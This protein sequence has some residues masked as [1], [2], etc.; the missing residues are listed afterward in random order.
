MIENYLDAV[1]HDRASDMPACAAFLLGMIAQFVSYQ[2]PAAAHQYATEGLTLARETGMPSAIAINLVGLA[3]AV[4]VD[5]PDQARALLAEA[6]RLAATLDYENLNELAGAVFIAA[7]LQEW[8]TVLRASGRVLHLFNRS[9]A[10]M[11]KVIMVGTLNFVT[12]GLAEHQPETAAVLQGAIGTMMRQLAPD[13]AA[14]ARGSTSGNDIAVFAGGVRRDTT[15]RLTAALGDA[16]LRE[17]R[18][19]GAA[20]DETQTYTYARAHIDEYLASSAEELK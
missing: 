8:P 9:G 20:M 2:D 3:Q 12:R 7:R 11:P 14:P 10:A 4:V 1:E 15:Q 5:D 17:L 13:V 19:Q 16:R 18:A 6:L